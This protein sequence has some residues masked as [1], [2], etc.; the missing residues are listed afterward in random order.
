MISGLLLSLFDSGSLIFHNG[1]RCKQTT[2]PD[3]MQIQSHGSYC[4]HESIDNKRV[5]NK[6]QQNKFIFEHNTPSQKVRLECTYNNAISFAVCSVVSLLFPFSGKLR[7]ARSPVYNFCR[8]GC[9]TTNTDPTAGRGPIREH[10]DYSLGMGRLLL[11]TA[12]LNTL[13]VF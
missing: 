5:H 13:A 1:T 7:R 6:M 8:Y 12:A 10:R 4:F 3:L 11:K 2:Y 9:A